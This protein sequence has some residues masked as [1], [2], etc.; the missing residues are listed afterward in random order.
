MVPAQFSDARLSVGAYITNG[1]G[2]YEVVGIDRTTT[3][4]MGGAYRIE[5]ENCRNLARIQLEPQKI[6]D[7]FAL[8]KA[9]PAAVVPDDVEHIAWEAA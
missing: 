9:A 4:Y 1:S 8:V 7:D 3:G 6:R 2:L 5:V